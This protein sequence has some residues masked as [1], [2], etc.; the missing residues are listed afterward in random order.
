MERKDLT[1]VLWK[2]SQE[3]KALTDISHFSFQI[4]T[5]IW[6]LQHCCT[7][8]ITLQTW[9][10]TLNTEIFTWP[11]DSAR[12]IHQLCWNICIIKRN[13]NSSEC[14][15]EASQ[16]LACTS[17]ALRYTPKR[18]LLLECFWLYIEGIMITCI[19]ECLFY[20]NACHWLISGTDE[21][22]F[23]PCILNSLTIDDEWPSDTDPPPEISSN[24]A[25]EGSLSALGRSNNS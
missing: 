11:E 1:C 18:L 6:H 4:S 17:T 19:D 14:V 10:T 8:K 20:C 7:S 13:G 3:T 9:K 15:F 5:V 16:L 23:D 2:A 24:Q 21:C 25:D 12:I 22:G